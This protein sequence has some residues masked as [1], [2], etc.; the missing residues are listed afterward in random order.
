MSQP[1]GLDIAELPLV[2]NYDV[3]FVPETMFIELAEQ[4]AQEVRAWH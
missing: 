4:V 1:R 3:P 2:I